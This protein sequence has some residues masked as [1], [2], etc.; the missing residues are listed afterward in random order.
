MNRGDEAFFIRILIIFGMESKRSM[1]T[2]A[3]RNFPLNRRR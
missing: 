2:E 3:L 1:G